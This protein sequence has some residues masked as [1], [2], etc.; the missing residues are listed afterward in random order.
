MVN[1]KGVSEEEIVLVGV[2]HQAFEKYG[3]I[4]NYK[5]N[6]T[7]YLLISAISNLE[8]DNEERYET[9]RHLKTKWEEHLGGS[10]G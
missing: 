1:W 5:E 10:I 9:N 4:T 2:I 8:K 3:V 6:R 7:G